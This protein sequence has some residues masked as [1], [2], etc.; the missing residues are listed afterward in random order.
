[1]MWSSKEWEMRTQESNGCSGQRGVT[2]IE[3]MVGL[4]VTLLIVGAGFTVLTTTQ[5][6][7]HANDQ[8]ANTQQSA[9]VA[10]DL[11]SRDIKLA[12]FG[13][14]GPVGACNSAL[15][16]ADNDPTG[17]DKGPD[18]I[19]LVV[20]LGNSVAPNA[21]TLLAAVGPGFNQIQLPSAAAVNNM[22]SQGMVANSMIS[23]GGSATGTVTG[24]SA[25]RINI[26]AL[27]APFFF[28]AGTPVY[29]LQCMRYQIGATAAACG[30][31]LWPCLLRGPVGGVLV[32]IADGIEDIQFA[33]GCDG[34]VATINLGA[35]NGIIDDQGGVG[36]T[37]GV[38]DFVTD[39]TWSGG[40]LTP[41]KIRLVQVTIVARQSLGV[42][43]QNPADEGFGEVRS[44][45]S[46]TA[47][48]IQV[49]DHN[50]N[51][52]VFT[53]GDY[54]GLLPPYT[55]YRRRVLTRTIETRNIGL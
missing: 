39:S 27:P 2:L 20:P 53:A 37:F 32:P 30:N 46:L 48:P 7:T 42:T 41:D 10:M 4:V 43:G 21:W 26:N 6:A 17:A 25:D 51:A 47:G 23:I 9:R 36:G 52:G 19:S 35:P 11:I 44:A 1:M 45:G 55:Q 31:G 50:P 16:P 54:A 22:V 15:V 13:M 33:Y 49:S 3:L 34:C 28:G 5:K 14:T 8:V 29:I 38:E 12:G 24:T 18:Q 40:S